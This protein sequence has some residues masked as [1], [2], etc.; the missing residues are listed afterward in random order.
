MRLRAL[1]PLAAA[2]LTYPYLTDAIVD[3]LVPP[4]A[5][6]QELSAEI[7]HYR[8]PV[9]CARPRDGFDCLACN[10]YFEA[11]NQPVAGQIEVARTVLAR[12]DDE[13]YPKT[14]CGVVWDR[15]PV[16]QYSWTAQVKNMEVADRASWQRAVNAA[17]SAFLDRQYPTAV[18]YHERHVKPNWPGYHK[19][20]TIGDHIFYAENVK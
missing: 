16:P 1:L 2:V 8:A 19:A 20:F 18:R 4:P 10:V 3:R 17:W 9:S 6:A 5:P 13:R 14:M 15:N 7:D 11:R 12:L